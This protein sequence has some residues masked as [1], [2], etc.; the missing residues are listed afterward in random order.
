MIDTAV[1]KVKAGKGGDG[2]VSFR[3]EKYIPKGGP[4]GGDGGDGGNVYLITDHNMATL[5]DFKSKPTYEGQNG[6]AG[7][8]V[9][10]SGAKGEDLYI[11]VPEGT[12]V[13]E[14]LPDR[15]ILLVDMV[16]QEDESQKVFLLARGGKGG[17]GNTRFK[18]STNRTPIQF[19]KGT[20]GDEKD[21][22]L[23]VK[24]VADIGL[25]GKPN[26]G[27]STLIN[28]LTNAN[29]KTASYPFTTL[30]P[31][32]GT[33]LLKSGQNV[34]IADIPGL[35]EGASSGKGLGDDFL[36]HIERTRVICHVIDPL[37]GVVFDP[38]SYDDGK[39]FSKIV[40]SNAVGCYKTIRQELSEY[41]SDLTSKPELVVV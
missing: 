27:K 2:K 25:V 1:I 19:T 31:N 34:I 13:Y 14:I 7:G 26:A 11:K 37:D 23:E 18:S 12:L 9:Q 5:L 10:M 28:K 24:L 22:Q 8:S 36:R 6:E 39:D 35:I 40:A 38:D 3:R 32:L 21:I 20:L 33:A 15:K 4:D 16:A 17:K 41:E 29:A 30:T